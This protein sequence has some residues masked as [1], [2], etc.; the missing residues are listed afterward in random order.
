MKLLDVDPVAPCVASAFLISVLFGLLTLVN[1]ESIWAD[2]LIGAMTFA[3]I[4]LFFYMLVM[5]LLW[6]LLAIAHFLGGEK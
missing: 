6:V 2:I 3:A 5:P 1:K 4:P